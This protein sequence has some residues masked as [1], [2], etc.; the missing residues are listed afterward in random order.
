MQHYSLSHNQSR[1]SVPHTHRVLIAGTNKPKLDVFL[2]PLK[3]LGV[4]MDYDELECILANLIFKV[5][6]GGSNAA[7]IHRFSHPP[8]CVPLSFFLTHRSWSKA[9]SHTSTAPWCCLQRTPSQ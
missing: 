4:N 7:L 9:T 5:R 3:A 1:A 2:I 6:W 8:C